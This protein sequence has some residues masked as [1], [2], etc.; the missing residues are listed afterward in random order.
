MRFMSSSPNVLKANRRDAIKASR[1]RIDI[2]KTKG[3]T[4][5]QRQFSC[6]KSAYGYFHLAPLTLMQ[7]V[8]F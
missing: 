3:H 1:G 5:F 4:T 2:C 6:V 8:V 7:S